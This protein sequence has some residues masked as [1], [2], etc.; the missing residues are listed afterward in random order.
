MLTRC[1]SRIFRFFRSDASLLDCASMRAASRDEK[2][3]HRSA[4]LGLNS[5]GE[6]LANKM[7]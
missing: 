1:T 6:D 7:S 3:G 2:K 4:R 5:G